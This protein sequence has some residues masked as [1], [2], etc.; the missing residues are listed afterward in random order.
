MYTMTKTY[1]NERGLSCCFRQH[2]ADSHCAFLH[3]YALGFEITLKS[4]VLNLQNWVY[5]FGKMKTFE[6]SLKALFDHKTVISDSDP[7]LKT[8]EQMYN[9]K[10]ID[11]VVISGAVGCEAFA[12][13]A[14]DIMTQE[15]INEAETSADISVHSVRV[16]EHGSN[17]ATYYPKGM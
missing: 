8:F 7:H 10:L 2:K 5:D 13:I 4:E 16:F 17:S 12:K 15:L 3:G 9:D 6:V 14:A 11:L 1:G